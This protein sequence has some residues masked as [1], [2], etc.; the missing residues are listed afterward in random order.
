MP[1]IEQLTLPLAAAGHRGEI[2]EQC[3]AEQVLKNLQNEYTK[4]LLSAVP[5]VEKVV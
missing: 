4:K 2:V 1:P 3:P 5:R